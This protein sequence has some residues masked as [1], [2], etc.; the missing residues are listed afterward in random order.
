MLTEIQKLLLHR[1]GN[2]I[3][4]FRVCPIHEAA[5]ENSELAIHLMHPYFMFMWQY[6]ML[7]Q[8]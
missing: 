7:E 5:D 4:T 6:A 8:A 1:S 2:V 3:F